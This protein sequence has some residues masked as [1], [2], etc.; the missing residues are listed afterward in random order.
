[1]PLRNILYVDIN[2]L[3][4][5]ISQIDGYTYEEETIVERS[6][7]IKDGKIGVG[8]SKVSAEG[9]AGKERAETHTRNAKVTDASKLDKVIKYLRKDNELKFFEGL[10]ENEWAELYREDFIEALVTPRFSK[11]GEL[12]LVA[13]KLQELSN[14]FQEFF[15]TPIID[16]KSEKAISGLRKI[17][18][19]NS[20]RLTCVFEF[21]DKNY[22]LVAYLNENNLLIPKENFNNQVTILCKIQKKIYKGEKIELDEVFEDF[23][24]LKL[25]R[26][27]RR[28]MPQN[29][30][31]PNEIKDVVKGPALVVI[32]VA[33]YQ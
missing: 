22:P 4:N 1:M 25:N 30:S 2:A 29:L 10:N 13:K 33:I 19:I 12:S 32:P 20:N 15:D 23:K 6:S 18:N 17:G 26:E 24:S 3:D 16:K 14:N 27:Q 7:N 28:K 21:E 31:N 5:Y 8:I 11:L 9:K